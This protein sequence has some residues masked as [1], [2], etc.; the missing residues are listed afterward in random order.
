MVVRGVING[1]NIVIELKYEIFRDSF[2]IIGLNY[3]IYEDQ[4]KVIGLSY[5]IYKDIVLSCLINRSNFS[6]FFKSC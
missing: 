6:S 3:R 2:R 1:I 5:R 4:F